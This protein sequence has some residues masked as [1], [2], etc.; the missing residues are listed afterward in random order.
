METEVRLEPFEIAR[1]TVVSAGLEQPVHGVT[2]R[3]AINHCNALSDAEGLRPAYTVEGPRTCWDVSADGY[4]LP[5]EAE[6]EYACRAGTTGPQYGRLR[7]I[8]WTARDEIHGIQPDVTQPPVLRPGG[9]CVTSPGPPG[10]KSTGSSPSGGNAPMPS[11]S[12]TCSAMSGSGAGTTSTRAVTPTTGS[13]EAAA[14]P[15]SRGA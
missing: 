2:W 8:A 12:R 15:T 13:S 1:T 4:R 11:G 6:W 14:G 7:D 3:D 9:G 10:T 5:T